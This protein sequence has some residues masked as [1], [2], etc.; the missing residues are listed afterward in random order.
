ME[1]EQT[2]LSGLYRDWMVDRE[3]YLERARTVAQLSLPYMY[4]R[5]SDRSTGDMDDPHQS[6]GAQ[7]FNELTSKIL[8]MLVPL[9]TPGF[10]I[11]VLVPEEADLEQ[12]QI[13]AINSRMAA[14]ESKVATFLNT[15]GART[16]THEAIGHV[17]MAGNV[18]FEWSR[19]D[20][21][22]RIFG[23]DQFVWRLDGYG[24]VYDI[25]TEESYAPSTLYAEFGELMGEGMV[26]SLYDHRHDSHRKI[27]VYTRVEQ[28]MENG[29]FGWWVTRQI[30][31][32]AVDNQDDL[33]LG[34]VEFYEDGKCPWFGA[35]YYHRSGEPY[36]RSYMEGFKDDLASLEAAYEALLE[37]GAL[38]SQI[39]LLLDPS[40]SLTVEDILNTPNGG[41]VSAAP[42]SIG[43][44]HFG[45]KIR[46]LQ[47]LFQLAQ[48][49]QDRIEESFMR[50]SSI[51]RQGERV[52]AE[53]MRIMA[54]AL[55]QTFVGGISSLSNNLQRPLHELAIQHC[56]TEKIISDVFAEDEV[57]IV[58]VGGL[59]ALSRSAGSQRIIAYLQTI[60]TTISMEL[61]H[62]YLDFP[63]ILQSLRESGG[64]SDMPVLLTPEQVEE[65]M[66]RQQEAA[67][68]QQVVP[69]AA[70]AGF[71]NTQN[72][73]Q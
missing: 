7:G 18:V 68:A 44:L 26:D 2:S 35:G 37:A 17:L 6:V 62:P 23:L 28:K 40:S 47:F 16:K 58:M 12:D 53:E 14:A 70:K 30:D 39:R 69:E 34:D 3:P 55:D 46:E 41:S 43:V 57:E 29:Q 4:P 8:L 38:M 33:Q 65:N 25:I 9:D 72:P 71:N 21:P 54:N 64:L 31:D 5:E 36:Y 56:I 27:K 52:T 19:S 48:T 1:A 15:S 20:E 22:P 63:G 67:L 24:R 59:E 61:A 13:R 10:R 66:A 49:I 45:E 51:Q 73:T 32:E 11:E 42:D 60:A 50:T